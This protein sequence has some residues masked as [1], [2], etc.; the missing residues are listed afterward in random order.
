MIKDN[1]KTSRNIEQA[2]NNKKYIV[3]YKTVYQPFYS[4]N[5]GYYANKVYTSKENMTRAGRFFHMTGE[6]VNK[7]IDIE[8]LNNL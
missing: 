6:Q 5:A 1:E 3:A 8:L 7:L 2:Y 4:V